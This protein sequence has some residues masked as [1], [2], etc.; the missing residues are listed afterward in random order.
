MKHLLKQLITLVLILLTSMSAWATA[1]V[2]IGGYQYNATGAISNEYI[3]SGSVYLDVENQKLTLTNAIINTYTY[4]WDFDEMTIELV[5]NNKITCNSYALNLTPASTGTDFTICGSGT[6]VATT[7]DS[8]GIFFESYSN[9]GTLTIKDCTLDITAKYSSMRS[10][11]NGSSN[12]PTCDLVIDNAIVMARVTY[13]SGKSDGAITSFKSIT[14]QGGAKVQ[15]PSNTEIYANNGYEYGIWD[16]AYEKAIKSLVIAPDAKYVAHNI[17]VG[18]AANG[19]ASTNVSSAKPGDLVTVTATPNSGYSLIG[20]TVT[21]SNGGDINCPITMTSPASWVNN[22]ATFF[23]PADAVTVTPVFTNELTTDNAYVVL[24]KTGSTTIGASDMAGVTSFKVYDDGGEER[25][26]SNSCNYTITF[27]APAGKV[28]QIEGTVDTEAGYDYFTVY[29]GA[30]T[31]D[32]VLANMVSGRNQVLGTLMG[33]Q[34]LTLN[35]ISDGSTSYSGLD[36]TVTVLTVTSHNITV[37]T[38]VGGSVTAPSSANTGEKVTLTATPNSGYVLTGYTINGGDVANDGAWYSKTATFTMPN[39]DVTVTPVFSNDVSSLSVNMPAANGMT[40]IDAS[41]IANANITKFTIYDSGGN[42]AHAYEDQEGTMVLNVP[43]GKAIMLTGQT[44]LYRGTL[45]IYDGNSTSASQLAE[46]TNYNNSIF[47]DISTFVSSG[48][49]L[50]VKHATTYHYDDLELTAWVIDPNAT[51]NVL[52]VGAVTGGTV[53]ASKT[54][55]K[56]GETITLTC[57]PS[58]GYKLANITATDATG[59]NILISGGWFT[60]TTATFTMSASDVTV[61]PVFT[62]ELT[63]AGGLFIPLP[64]TGTTTLTA[65]QLEGVSSFKIYGDGCNRVL[66]T[67]NFD[68][69]LDITVGANQIFAVSGSVTTGTLRFYKDNTDDENKVL[70]IRYNTP[71]DQTFVT[72]NHMI[73]HLAT[74]SQNQ[75]KYLDATIEIITN[76]AHTI[77]VNSAVG[78]TVVASATESTAGET[79]TL[80]A[81]PASGYKLLG[82]TVNGGDVEVTGGT[83]Y[84]NVATFVMPS[85]NATVVPVFTNNLTTDNLYINIPKTGEFVLSESNLENVLSFKVYDHGG[86][87]ANYDNSCNGYLKMA[88]TGAV[89]KISGTATTESTLYDWLTIYDGADNTAAVLG[90]EKYGS[91]PVGETIPELISSTNKLTLYFRSDGSTTYAGL[92]LTI[93]FVGVAVHTITVTQSAGG[94]VSAPAQACQGDEVTL[95]V[96]PDAGKYLSSISVN[97]VVKNFEWDQPNTFFMPGADVTIVPTFSNLPNDLTVTIPSSGKK[98]SAIPSN[99]TTFQV[100]DENGDNNYGNNWSGYLTIIAP[101]GYTMNIEGTCFTEGTVWDWMTIYD[102]ADDTA[103]VLGNSKYGNKSG[104]STQITGLTTTGNVVTIFFCSDHSGTEA[105]PNLTITLNSPS[106]GDGDVDEDGDVD[107]DDINAIARM[108]VNKIA[109]KAAADMNGDGKITVVDVTKAV[110]KKKGL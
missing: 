32:P 63:A 50:T 77:T 64:A 49:S 104:E 99:I 82:F 15:S 21:G 87:D 70:E 47:N 51:H 20:V 17:T 45:S 103:A 31:S 61:T 34:S 58:T 48:E 7:T 98:E 13:T 25:S 105:G 72:S 80:T 100:K 8:Y 110:N 91:N 89:F 36:L 68:G 86:I 2:Q 84:N 106:A 76:S 94:T 33:G 96:T 46:I 16:N 30:T 109:K 95:T 71:A 14:L 37:N 35:F 11:N 3:T 4:I 107:N 88:T 39:E 102:G 9:P 10:S 73:V 19:S 52:G 54:S 93:T 40:S 24:P 18:S 23:M 29:N 79:I 43:S 97:G 26:Y 65:D 57:T 101:E 62:N 27:T 59:R 41:L 78:G 60:Q 90:N 55:A 69:M 12:P 1:T 42:A 66:D 5:G 81:T 56:A 53:S 83:W 38:A 75:D 108:A 28:L 6:L 67:D 92:D 44:R 22:T 85:G 74:S